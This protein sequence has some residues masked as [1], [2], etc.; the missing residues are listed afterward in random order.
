M[1]E[2]VFMVKLNSIQNI[3]LRK[4]LY[5]MSNE[6]RIGSE[7][8]GISKTLVEEIETKIWDLVT[9]ELKIKEKNE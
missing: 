6:R 4:I 3:A 8:K 2:N 5:D 7:L 9:I 1:K